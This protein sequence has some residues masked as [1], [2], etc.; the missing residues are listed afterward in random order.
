MDAPRHDGLNERSNIL[1]LNR[2]LTGELIIGKTTTITTKRH[3]LILYGQRSSTEM[4]SIHKSLALSS[5]F[6]YVTSTLSYPPVLCHT[7]LF[8]L[9]IGMADTMI[10]FMQSVFGRYTLSPS[11]SFI[12]ANGFWQ[13][14]G[15]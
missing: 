14:K 8:G 9:K 12:L 13:G 3:R 15:K 7:K 10:H 1:I 6:A 11:E 2:S 4:L 5:I